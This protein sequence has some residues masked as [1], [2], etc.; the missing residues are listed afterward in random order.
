[1]NP[2]ARRAAALV[3]VGVALAVTCAFLGR[4]QWD[5][6][7]WRDAGIAVVRTNC[8]GR[9]RAARPRARLPGRA[10]ARTRTSGA[11]DRGRALRA[12]RRPSCCATVRSTAL[13]RTTCSCRS[14]CR[15]RPRGRLRRR[16]TPVRCSSSTAAGCE[17][18]RTA[19]ADVVPP[20]PPDG[21]V[22]LTARLRPDEPA[23]SRS[24]R[25]VRCR[26]SRWT[27]C[28]PPAG[29]DAAPTYDAYGGMIA[30]SPSAADGA[31]DAPATEHRPRLAPVVRVPVVGVRARRVPG[32]L[33]RCAPRAP[34]RACRARGRGT[35]AR[36]RAGRRHGGRRRAGPTRDTPRRAAAPRVRAADV[37][38]RRGGRDEDDEDALID[39]QLA[40][41]VGPDDR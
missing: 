31:R 28:W 9:P 32:V 13:R 39:A 7:V 38:R 27:R 2:V 25:P 18:A 35:G 21:S 1:M 24:A 30:E 4:W 37:P 26:R 8:G 40:Q 11:R 23:S 20:A 15:T 16:C 33:L 36:T 14:S 19:D 12:R 10:A 3:L 6:H 5:R 34:G 29:S 17:R 41:S 22:T